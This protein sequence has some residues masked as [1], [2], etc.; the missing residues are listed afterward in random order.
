M[1]NYAGIDMEILFNN[2]NR[3][4]E[5]N[6]GFIIKLKNKEKFEFPKNLLMKYNVNKKIIT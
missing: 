5:V 3:N 1:E 4:D 6:K 2:I